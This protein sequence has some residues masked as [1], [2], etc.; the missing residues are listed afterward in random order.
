VVDVVG[1]V[2]DDWVED[3][4]GRVVEPEPADDVGA[5]S[6]LHPAISSNP[7]RRPIGRRVCMAGILPTAPPPR[8]ADGATPVASVRIG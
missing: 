4:G 6:P 7:A 2:V 5:A 3:A 1:L 8:M